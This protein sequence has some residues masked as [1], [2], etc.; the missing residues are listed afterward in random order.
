MGSTPRGHRS[1][2]RR[3]VRSSVTEPSDPVT[4]SGG[5]GRSGVVD[6]A[7][8]AVPPSDL[9]ALGDL[10]D[11]VVG[12]DLDA[13]EARVGPALCLALLDAPLSDVGALVAA[14]P[15]R[16][17]GHPGLLILA[18][19]LRE[20]TGDDAA[21]TRV[22]LE[23][24][25]TL[26]DASVPTGPLDELRLTTLL[27]LAAVGLGA[28]ARARRGLAR[29]VEL[30]PA[31][32]AVSDDGAAADLPVALTLAMWA[33]GRLDEHGTALRLARSVRELAESV[34]LDGV[35]RLIDAAVAAELDF[36]GVGI[37]GG[38]VFDTGDGDGERTSF[39]GPGL[40]GVEVLAR[41]LTEPRAIS[42]AELAETLERSRARWDDGTAST[43]V[44]A[45][46][47]FAY[48]AQGD[49]VT[50]R[51]VLRGAPSADWFT[52]TALAVW[53]VTLND[54][55]GAVPLLR[56]AAVRCQAP[57]A[58]AVVEVVSA[59]AQLRLGR[60]DIA[61]VHLEVLASSVPAP[62][63]RFAL[64][65]VTREDLAELR[66]RVEPA[67]PA[68]R[69]VLAA[70]DASGPVLRRIEAL[71]LSGA[72]R[73]TIALLRAGLTNAEIARRRF[74]SINTVR[75]QLRMLFRKL[76]VSSRAHAV[77]R[78]EQLGLVEDA[79]VGPPSA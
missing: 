46:T 15:E 76:G 24:A 47:S 48:L 57:R 53:H 5:A 3:A 62:L 29:V 52:L 64:G 23:R 66:A 2:Y 72:E 63:V 74:V 60:A 42:R 51:K 16:L 73:E 18:A 25:V 78:A 39:A 40:D 21:R 65:F 75:T 45:A 79:S 10:G 20:R 31:L 7:R 61:T 13:A 49:A 54:P 26:L 37:E 32:Q 50:S 70:A 4:A 71:R 77:E 28:R 67:S 6:D 43:L 34:R 30:V 41:A 68:L 9:S 58:H 44:K 38:A 55:A 36:C 69:S 35:G 22:D 14:T 8:G 56:E 12:D 33:A 1:G 17:E 27:L 59:A 11:L 19:A